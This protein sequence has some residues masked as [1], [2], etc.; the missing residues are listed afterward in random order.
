MASMV[1]LASCVT[2][3]EVKITKIGTTYTI[4]EIT[5][6]SEPDKNFCYCANSSSS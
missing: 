3:L 1:I 2:Q 5:D 4:Y 6:V